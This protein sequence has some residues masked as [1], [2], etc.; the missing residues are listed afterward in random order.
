[1]RFTDSD[2][3]FFLNIKLVFLLSIVIHIDCLHRN[4]IDIKIK[5]GHGYNVITKIWD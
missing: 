3:I 2:W 1:M 4:I 5:Y